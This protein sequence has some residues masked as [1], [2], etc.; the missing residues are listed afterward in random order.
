MVLSLTV[1]AMSQNALAGLSRGADGWTVLTPSA[2]SR[3]VYVSTSEGSDSNDGL[4]PATPVRTIAKATSLM[5]DEMPDWML[6]KR[7]DKFSNQSFGDWTLRGRSANE[8]MVLGA[9]GS[10]ARPLIQTGDQ[11]GISGVRRGTAFRHIAIQGLHFHGNGNTG[12]GKPYGIRFDSP[13]ANLLIEDTKVEGY[14][15]NMVFQSA[16]FDDWRFRNLEIRRSVIIDAFSS[17]DPNSGHAQGIFLNHADG[18]LIEE[19]VIDH[20][21]WVEGSTTSVPTGNNHNIYVQDITKGL[22][23]RGNIISNASSNGLQARNGGIVEENLFVNNSIAFFIANDSGKAL[24]NVVLHGSNRG[25]YPG[26]APRAWGVDMGNVAG[27]QAIGNIIAHSANG[28]DALTGMSGVYSE[29]NI[30]YKWGSSPPLGIG[31]LPDPERT[32]ATYDAW[33]RNLPLGTLGS[34][35]H[36]LQQARL[37]SR[38]NWNDKYSAYNAIDYFRDGFGLTHMPEPQVLGLLLLGALALRRRSRRSS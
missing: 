9:Y 31:P 17:K 24:N 33:I 25:L 11:N 34:L 29:D 1:A 8:R 14:K 10:G 38:D 35:E 23:V 21:G 3:V 6:L 22:V 19:N 18:V 4:S 12:A 20:N 26:D 7:G 13:G 36:F 16:H 28:R 30:V 37:Q 5:R 2:D 27:S 15:D 32:M